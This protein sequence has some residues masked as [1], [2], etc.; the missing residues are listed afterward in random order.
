MIAPYAFKLA[1]RS[2]FREKWIN[3]LSILTIT[4]GLLIISLA[5][6]SVYNLDVATKKLPEKFSMVI[7][8]DD[9]ISN[10]KLD[11]IMNSLKQNSAVYS[12]RYI[13][14][15]EAMK[16]LKGILK[17]S[18]YI[19]EGIEENPLPDSL[20]L[21]LRKE[22]VGPDTVKRLAMEALKYEGVSEVD[23]GEKFV[24]TIHYLKVGVKSIGMILIAILATG[25]IFVCY[26]T[27]KILFYRRNEEIETFK[28]LGAT[29]G[30]IRAPFLIE[31]AVIGTG[32]G[33][34]SLAGMFAFYYI[35]L[36][37]LSV[38]M[39]VFKAILFPLNIFLFLPLIGL[40]LGITGAAI[41]L[42]RL[43]Y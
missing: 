16:E 7:Y 2:L 1:I 8:L 30:F 25:I 21:K 6:F 32:G 39:P 34:L 12:I 20:E 3:L 38:A 9:A 28:L 11:S 13:S 27:V 35:V 37:R 23:Y 24:S 22:D 15:E 31:G 36:L 33:L 26:S 14:K 19:L 10:E 17:N 5:F 4:A 43:R 29:K 41:A 40:F 18:D 42:G